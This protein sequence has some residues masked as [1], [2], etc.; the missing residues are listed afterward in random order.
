MNRKNVTIFWTSRENP[1]T[2]LTSSKAGSLE[3]GMSE[4][5]A[6]KFRR[7][8]ISAGHRCPRSRTGLNMLG[9]IFLALLTVLTLI[10]GLYTHC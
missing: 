4:L 10:Q 9:H 7:R 3:L 8:E 2:S 1:Y 5:S 6:G